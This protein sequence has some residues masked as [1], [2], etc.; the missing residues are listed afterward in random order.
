MKRPIAWT[1][2]KL[3]GDILYGDIEQLSIGPGRLGVDATGYKST[4]V[5]SR[6]WPGSR[7]FLNLWREI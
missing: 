1:F 4:I 6:I 3:Y 7:R 5:I 2:G